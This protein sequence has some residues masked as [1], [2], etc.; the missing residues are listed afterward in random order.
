MLGCVLPTAA[1]L[2]EI[3]Q[4]LYPRFAEGRLGMEILP[5]K[6]V[7]TDS[8]VLYQKDIFKGLQ[9]F[10]GLGKPV[11]TV[12]QHTLGTYTTVKPGYW[13]EKDEVGEEEMTKW[14]QP[15]SNCSNRTIDLTSYITML[16][17]RLMERRYNRVEFNIWQLLTFGR[18]QA[19]NTLGQVVFQAEFNITNVSAEIPWTDYENASPLNDLRAVQL[20]EEGTS[21]RFDSCARMIMNRR[22]ANEL[23]KNRN[24]FDVGRGIVSACCSLP[25]PEWFNQQFAAQGLA[26]MEIYNGGYVDDSGNFQLYIPT[27]YVI[28]VGCRPGDVPPGHYYLTRNVVNCGVDSGFWQKI[29]DNCAMDFTRKIELGDGHNGGPALEYP[30]MVVVMRVF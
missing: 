24:P 27:G 18:Y 7:D 22:T 21:A 13:G 6:T 5:F 29:I 25:G 10:R 9:A 15:G 11:M 8:I 30:R 2:I 19:L 3:Q 17:E 4:E 20:L 1:E 14:A 26:R 12:P 28:I 23:F 16:Q